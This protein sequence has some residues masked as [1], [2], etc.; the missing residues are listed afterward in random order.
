MIECDGPGGAELMILDLAKELR[1][2][3]HAVLPVGLSAG[4]GWLGARFDA[5]GFEPA[6]FELRRPLDFAAVRALTTLL[7][8]FRAEVV[9]SHEFTMAIYGAAAARRAQ[10]APRDHDARWAVLRDAR[11]VAARRC[12]GPRAGALRSWASPMPRPARSSGSS[13]SMA[14]RSTWYRTEFRSAPACAT[15]CARELALAPGELLI[16]VRRESVR[17]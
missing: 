11:G 7:R 14:R 4:T 16:V 17:R 10:R 13:A 2:R 6:S 15:R 5:A 3:G 9:H 1:S 12:A 8:D